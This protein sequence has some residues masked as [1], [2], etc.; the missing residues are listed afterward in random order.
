MAYTNLLDYLKA[1]RG[2]AASG[3]ARLA[4]QAEPERSAA[5]AALKGVRSSALGAGHEAEG[6]A[7]SDET[8]PWA[9]VGGAEAEKAAQAYGSRYDALMSGTL[10]Q[11]AAATGGNA[12]DAWLTGVGMGE[13]KR[14]DIGARVAAAK[15]RQTAAHESYLRAGDA[16]RKRNEA[17][18]NPYK[19]QTPFLW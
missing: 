9:G 4:A 16:K 14:S 12:R 8:L 17:L 5:E 10:G 3:G 1:N 2:Y 6:F 19:G 11:K 7:A 15:T 18:A 13:L